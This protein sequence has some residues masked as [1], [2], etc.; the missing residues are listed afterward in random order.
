MKRKLCEKTL[1]W[2]SNN[3]AN[4]R[5][6]KFT[7]PLHRFRSICA[8][9]AIDSRG[10]E[11]DD[12]D[13]KLTETN[14]GQTFCSQWDAIIIANLPRRRRR[15][16]RPGVVLVCGIP[17]QCPPFIFLYTLNLCIDIYIYI[18]IHEPFIFVYFFC[19]SSITIKF[20]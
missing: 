4:Y 13:I 1:N 9:S 11:D 20:I 2:L 17:C 3:R 19:F 10:D 7:C 16:R 14:R 5:L 18:Y 8:P 12:D 15:R 6:D